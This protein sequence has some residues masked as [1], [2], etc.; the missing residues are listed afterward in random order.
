M[1]LADIRER[2]SSQAEAG[3]LL[4]EACSSGASK[5]WREYYCESLR[6]RS[7]A[8]ANSVSLAEPLLVSGYQGMLANQSRMPAGRL[9]HIADAKAALAAIGK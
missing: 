3:A 9:M 7:L 1:I 2:R 8:A 4:E 6:G 5:D